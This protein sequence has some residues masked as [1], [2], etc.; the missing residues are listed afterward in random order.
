MN[1]LR[2]VSTEPA[3]DELSLEADAV[4]PQVFSRVPHSIDPS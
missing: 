3:D 2:I 1:D 4:M